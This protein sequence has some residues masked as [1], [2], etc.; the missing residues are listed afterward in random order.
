MI[1]ER[2]CDLQ[3]NLSATFEGNTA[4]TGGRFAYAVPGRTAGRP[5]TRPLID[6]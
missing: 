3:G 5:G 4:L 1:P 2:L 6:S